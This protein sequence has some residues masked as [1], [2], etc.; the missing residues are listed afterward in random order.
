M[1]EEKDKKEET[2]VSHIDE[3]RIKKL[4][5]QGHYVSLLEE[6]DRLKAKLLY[7]YDMDKQEAHKLIT[8]TKYFLKNAHSEGFRL[9]VQY[10]YDK[11]IKEYDL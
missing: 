8:L 5:V 4:Q 10:I 1:S 3:Q 2:N 7:G 11:Y 6:F 9:H